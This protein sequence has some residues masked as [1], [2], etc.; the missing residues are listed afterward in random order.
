MCLALLNAE[1]MIADDAV[2]IFLYI[3]MTTI[4]VFSVFQALSYLLNV[5]YIIW[6]SYQPWVIRTSIIFIERNMSFRE[7]KQGLMPERGRP[8]LSGLLVFLYHVSFSRSL[9]IYALAAE[10]NILK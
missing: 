1:N 6:S 8:R 5:H 9:G 2:F 3:I 4:C 10:A 7:L